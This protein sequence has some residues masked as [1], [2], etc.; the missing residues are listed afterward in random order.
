MHAETLVEPHELPSDLLTTDAAATHL[1]NAHYGVAVI[2][3]SGSVN[4]NKT[5]KAVV[6]KLKAFSG[7][8]GGAWRGGHVLYLKNNV[9]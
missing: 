6:P 3:P 8:K 4:F 1:P 2:G 5:G 9:N 7:G